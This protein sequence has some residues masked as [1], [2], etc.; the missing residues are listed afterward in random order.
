MG[1]LYGGTVT[2]RAFRNT[3]KTFHKAGIPHNVLNARYHEREAEIVA[4]AGRYGA[5]TI[6]TNMAGR[7]RDIMLGG[8]PEFLARQEMRKQGYD[9]EMIENSTAFNVTDDETILRARDVFARLKERFTA[10]IAYEKESVIEVGG[11]CIVGTERHESRRIDNQLRGRAG[12]QGDPDFQNSISR[13]RM[14]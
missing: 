12:R 7:G 5:V 11:L 1:S 13:L 3:I 10:E 9:E 8:N 4:Q 6:A 14:I 2:G